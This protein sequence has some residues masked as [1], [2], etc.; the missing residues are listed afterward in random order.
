MHASPVQSG[1]PS[2]ET[3]SPQCELQ[4]MLTDLATA[5]CSEAQHEDSQDFAAE[6]DV[7]E[8]KSPSSTAIANI[9][10]LE[11]SALA[12]SLFRSRCLWYQQVK[13]GLGECSST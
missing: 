8:N 4:V 6:D 7:K 13:T 9:P 10:A 12:A 5:Q 11:R 3:R 2:D 1:M